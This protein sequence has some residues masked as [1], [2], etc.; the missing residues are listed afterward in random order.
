MCNIPLTIAGTS[1][2]Q[3][4]LLQ[5]RRWLQ[6]ERAVNRFSR[7]AII[8]VEKLFH[9]DPA[10]RTSNPFSALSLEAKQI[11]ATVE[12]E[13]EAAAAAAADGGNAAGDWWDG[14]GRK[15]VTESEQKAFK[16]KREREKAAVMVEALEKGEKEEA[17]LGLGVEE[18]EGM[19]DI[20]AIAAVGEAAGLVAMTAEDMGLGPGGFDDLGFV[21]C[22]D[23]DLAEDGQEEREGAEKAEEMAGVDKGEG[24]DMAMDLD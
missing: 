6:N 15:G 7:E 21:S 2:G 23:D 4:Q 11:V 10:I 14:P 12:T 20:G 24:D 3:E 22:D 17:M 9:K 18:E 5:S 1:T 19:A 8:E 13:R 16:E